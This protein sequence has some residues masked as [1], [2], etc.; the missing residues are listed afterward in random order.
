VL[1]VKKSR[2]LVAKEAKALR[3][4]EEDG[5][6]PGGDSDFLSGSRT[7]TGGMSSIERSENS[8]VVLPGSLPS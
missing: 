2:A 4:E 8:S 3:G 7:G 5:S 1:S 6:L